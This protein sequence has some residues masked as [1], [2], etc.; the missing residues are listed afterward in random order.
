MAVAQT[1]TRRASR[2]LDRKLGQLLQAGNVLPVL[3]MVSIIFLVAYPLVMVISSSFT[4]SFPGQAVNWTLENW[5]LLADPS[6]YGVFAS[7]FLIAVPRT[8]LALALATLFAWI[9]ARTNTPYRSTLAGLLAFMFFLPDL[10]WIIAWIVMGAPNTGLFNQWASSLLGHK[11]TIIN[12]YS[13]SGLI[14][15]GAVRSAPVLFLFIY[16]VFK[17]IDASL[18][19]SARIS[20]ASGWQMVRKINLPLIMPSLLGVGI[21]SFIRALESFEMEQLLGTPARI[22]VFTT[23]IY[24]LI[25]GGYPAHYGPATVLSTLLL[26]MT[27]LL[28]IVQWKVISGKQYTTITGR[29][30]QAKPLDIGRWRWLTFALIMG[31]FLILGALPFVILT[32]QSFMQVSGFLRLDMFT[33]RHWVRVLTTPEVIQ[34][35]RNTILVGVGSATLGV[36]LSLLVSYV[37]TRTRW[38]GRRALDL[39][40]WT[41]WAVPGM[42]LGLGFLWA[43]VYLPIYGTLW[44]L[45]LVFVARGLPN[46]TRFFTGPMLQIGAEL[47]E[48][49]RI[50][51]ASWLKTFLRIW[52]PLLRPAILG[53]W[54]L[55]MVIA[56]RVV[57]SIVFLTGPGLRMLSTDIFSWSLSGNREGAFVLAIVQTGLILLTYLMARLLLGRTPLEENGRAGTPTT[58]RASDDTGPAA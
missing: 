44:V 12:V 28:V 37:V 17:A 57:D 27:F 36:I 2:G 52:V 33:T 10:P 26:A 11:V 50:H 16:P 53:S 43:Y 8:F 15:L 39:M 54:I 51:G 25:Y 7:T 5:R 18:E 58:G 20:G 14:I 56:M 19:E 34:S 3:L 22:F 9:V 1:P 55:L 41:P 42:V 23:K 30:Y 32:L 35:I 6:I 48:S 38:A 49:A 4:G 29:G 46:G 40:A 13:Y 31:F 45:V 47:E 21:L 24:D